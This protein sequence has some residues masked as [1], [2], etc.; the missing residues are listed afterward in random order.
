MKRVIFLLFALLMTTSVATASDVRRQLNEIRSYINADPARALSEL[1][2][3]ASP[4]PPLKG[5]ASESTGL[6]SFRRG[7]GEAALYALLRT[8]AADKCLIPH[9]S[10][11][12]ILTAVEYY[13]RPGRNKE[14]RALSQFYLGSVCRDL[15]DDFRAVEAYL[16]AADGFRGL[17]DWVMLRRTSQNIAD[18]LFNQ[19]LFDESQTW[20]RQAYDCAVR[21]GDSLRMIMPLEGIA[22]C[23][24]AKGQWDAS[25]DNYVTL[26]ALSRAIDNPIGTALAAEQL[27][28]ITRRRGNAADALAYASLAESLRTGDDKRFPYYLKGQAYKALGQPDSALH[29]L[30]LCQSATNNLYLEASTA[31]ALASLDSLSGQFESAFGH[32]Q[33]YASLKETI[34]HSVDQLRMAGVLRSYEVEVHRRQAARHRVLAA[35]LVALVGGM[36]IALTALRRSRR[37]K[38]QNSTLYFE[39]QL[40]ACINQFMQ[41]PWNDELSAIHLSRTRGFDAFSSERTSALQVEL[42]R[43]FRPIVDELRQQSPTLS[44]SE[45]TCLLL[46]RLGFSTYTQTICTGVT[47][48]TIRSHKHRLRAKLA[49]PY[50]SIFKI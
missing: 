31:S 12:L 20:Y 28:I 17:R 26:L 43:I 47:D 21:V 3:I 33:Y 50:L 44:D 36:L 39:E 49:E 23:Q 9:T 35:L 37:A 38:D 15:G 1:D 27:S 2:S 25:Y 29:Y 41:S 42:F 34:A 22:K 18:H 13:A 6:P 24:M 8:Q 46:C 40:G 19:H 11:S 48:T 7:K 30:R 10:D 16:P 14:L 32:A 45:L 5:R 4:N